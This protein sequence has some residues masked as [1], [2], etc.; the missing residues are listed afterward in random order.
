MALGRD[1]RGA[2]QKKSKKKVEHKHKTK[3]Q[4]FMCIMSAINQWIYKY[5]YLMKT[6]RKD[7]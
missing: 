5:I 6:K 2:E 3:L 1:G 7:F 4:Y